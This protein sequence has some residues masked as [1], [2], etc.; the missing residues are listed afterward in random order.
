[1]ECAYPEVV[2]IA[3]ENLRLPIPP[4]LDARV[5]RLIELCLKDDPGKRPRFDSQL[6][7]LLDKMR[8]RAG[9]YRTKVNSSWEEFAIEQLP[10]TIAREKR[11]DL[12][13]VS[14]ADAEHGWNARLQS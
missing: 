3:T 1:M 5:A 6:I 2:I 12:K 7:Q 14:Q 4:Q 8:E 9:Q 13:L 10:G 11:T